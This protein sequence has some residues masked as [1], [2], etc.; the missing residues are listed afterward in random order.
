LLYSETVWKRPVSFET[1]EYKINIQRIN[2]SKTR[3]EQQSRIEKIS[4]VAFLDKKQNR[5]F[6]NICRALKRVYSKFYQ[7]SNLH[8]TLL[9]LVRF[10][11]KPLIK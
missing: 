4:L 11:G 5:K 6:F 7:N 9:D 3:I 1:H 10:L 8:V 2:A